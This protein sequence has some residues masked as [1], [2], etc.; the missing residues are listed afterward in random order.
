MSRNESAQQLNRPLGAKTGGFSYT[1]AAVAYVIVSFMASIIISLCGAEYGSDAYIYISYIAAQIGI[2]LAVIVTMRFDNVHFRQAFP[3]KCHPKYFIIG[4]LIIF[5]LMFSLSWVNTWFISL[6]EN[7][8]YV[9]RESTSYYPTLS[10]GLIVPALLV[11]A[12]LPAICEEALFRGV[13]FN[14]VNRSIG[15]IPAIFIVG[16]CFSLFHGSPEQTVYQFIAGCLFAFIAM[17]SGSILPS[18]MMHFLNNGVII[19]LA[20]AGCFDAA[21]DLIISSTG[22]I[23]L[24]AVSAACLV[25]GVLWLCLDRHKNKVKIHEGSS[26]ET[27]RFFMW[28]AVGIVIMLVVW[29]CV[30]FGVA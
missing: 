6:F 15:S 8:G 24:M 18:V 25:A 27:A 4:A 11:I 1:A 5:G 12:V 28:G 10:G 30:L 3:V 22:N 2:L 7:L 29:F 21:G 17:R 14:S 16:F 9:P 13:L 19:I 23:I 20:A 26:K